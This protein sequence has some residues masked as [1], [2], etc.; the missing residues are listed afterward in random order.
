MRISPLTTMPQ[1]APPATASSPIAMTS[2]NSLL[3]PIILQHLYAMN[4]C[5][6]IVTMNAGAGA[7]TSGSLRLFNWSVD[8]SCTDIYAVTAHAVSSTLRRLQT[9]A[10]VRSGLAKGMAILP[11]RAGIAR[12]HA[13]PPRKIWAIHPIEQGI[14]ISL[15]TT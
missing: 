1:T 4:A 6:D 9:T 7:M 15:A 2:T 13:I 14:R 11:F 5:V 3:L 8:L 10:A 12:M